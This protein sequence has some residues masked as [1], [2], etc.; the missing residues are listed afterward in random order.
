MNAALRRFLQD[1]W[2]WLLFTVF[3][4]L[5]IHKEIDRVLNGTWK[6]GPDMVIRA[7]VETEEKP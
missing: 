2:P 1:Q 3:M 4:V 7:V 6:L 5:F